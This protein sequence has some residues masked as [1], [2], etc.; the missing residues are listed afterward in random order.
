[1]C[2]MDYEI[3]TEYFQMKW[4]PKDD[5]KV[6]ISPFDMLFFISVESDGFAARTSMRVNRQEF[7]R[8][9]ADLKTLYE[10]RAGSVRLQEPLEMYNYVE[11][12]GTKAGGLH[13]RGRLHNHCEHGLW[14]ELS[15]ENEVDREDAKRFV[16]ELYE[17]Y[18]SQ[19]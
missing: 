6:C 19:P 13:I 12:T 10:T 2:S 18:G 7:A 9:A 14:Q 11:C 1:M 4:E 17:A 5:S 8:F 16:F 15:F 3:K